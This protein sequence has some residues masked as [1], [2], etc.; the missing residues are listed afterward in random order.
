MTGD[1]PTRERKSQPAAAPEPGF[2]PLNAA[3]ALALI[4]GLVTLGA[5]WF[6]GRQDGK[7]ISKELYTS[8]VD[9]SA[10]VDTA[11]RGSS[12]LR[13][14]LELSPPDSTP[15]VGCAAL[16]Q[17][18]RSQTQALAKIRF[19]RDPDG[20]RELIAVEDTLQEGRFRARADELAAGE[21]ESL[22]TGVSALLKG[23]CRIAIGEGSLDFGACPPP[24]PTTEPTPLPTAHVVLDAPAEFIQR[25]ALALDAADGELRLSLASRERDQDA[26]SVQL[27]RSHDRGVSFKFVTGSGGRAE[28]RP[29]VPVVLYR[30]GAPSLVLTTLRDENRVYSSAWVARIEAGA[31]RL[32]SAIEL[33]ALPEGLEPLVAGTPLWL[34][35]DAKAGAAPLIFIGPRDPSRQGGAALRL[36]GDGKVELLSTPPGTLIA[37]LTRPKPRLIVVERAPDDSAQLALYDIPESGWKWGSPLRLPLPTGAVVAEPMRE[38]ACG[39][40]GETVFPFV[41]RRARRVVD[42]A[43]RAAAA[44]LRARARRRRGVVAGLWQLSGVA[45]LG[46]RRHPAFAVSGRQHAGRVA[47]CCPARR[48]RA[49]QRQAQ[50]WHL[51][52]RGRAGGT[53]HR[54][55]C[56]DAGD[57]HR[58]VAG[59]ASGAGGGA[60]R[61]RLARRRAGG[62]PRRA[63]LRG[64]APRHPHARA[65]RDAHERRRRPQLALKTNASPRTRYV[66]GEA[67]AEGGT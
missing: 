8:A 60:E 18:V 47:L 34:V 46:Q 11:K 14:E 41:A 61:D 50:R 36:G 56:A 38:A 62:G 27:G 53:R 13:D 28:G 12:A 20:V 39:V 49:P 57:S 10:C 35:D 31:A 33:P 5:I 6:S 9:L 2:R 30:H 55:P 52:R 65:A 25:T 40:H 64:L 59:R 67:G 44:C 45:A 24:S 26:V 21:V 4:A 63:V 51:R 48:D 1:A 23:A 54:R 17:R 7:R 29:D 42:C 16:A 58:Q 37:L 19:K 22:E 43:R 15:L 32:G 3:G 66:R